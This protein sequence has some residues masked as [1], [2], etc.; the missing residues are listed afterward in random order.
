MHIT[1]GHTKTLGLKPETSRAGSYEEP[2][3]NNHVRKDKDP[4]S[5]TQNLFDTV[6]MR[7]LHRTN[8]SDFDLPWAPSNERTQRVG[9]SNRDGNRVEPQIDGYLSKNAEKDTEKHLI[10]DTEPARIAHNCNLP[11]I[12]CIHD[13]TPVGSK[14]TSSEVIP[15]RGTIQEFTNVKRDPENLET[16][17]DDETNV[18]VNVE[19]KESTQGAAPLEISQPNPQSKRLN[20]AEMA[21]LRKASASV[22]CLSVPTSDFAAQSLSHFT[23]ANIIALKEARAV[24]RSDLYEQHCLLKSLGRTDLPQHSS[25]CGSYGNF[26]A[27]SGQS[28]TYI[29]GHVDALLQSFL[30]FEDSD[31]TS[32]VVWSYDFA[33][34]VDLFRKLRRIDM[35]PHKIFPSLWISVGR[36]YPV[37]ATTNKSR[38]LTISDPGSFSLDP[39]SASPGCSLNDLEA[40]HVVKIVLA[41]LVASVPKCSPLGWL[42]VRKLH[43]A[44]QVAPFVDAGNSP[45][46]GKM[47]GKLVRVLQAFENESALSLV[48]RLA[49][50]IDIRYHLARARELAED[51]EKKHRRRYPPTFSRVIDYI[52]ADKLKV[53]VA[54]NGGQPSIKSGEWVDPDIEP[55]TWH[56]KEWPIVVEWLRAV[57]L[58]EWDGNAKV[59]KGSAVGGALGLMLY[60]RKQS[61]AYL[62]SR[63]LS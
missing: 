55:I 47:I 18:A 43:A 58:K 44:G 33:T 46:E 25:R 61:I 45:A 60:I 41:A 54:G 36:L 30:H 21:P 10:P 48:I 23:S 57:I 42:A 2:R 39:S 5:F 15:D 6:A 49:R 13:V 56:R 14:N 53:S 29:L 4:K 22:E 32:K 52:N 50:S 27:Y 3:T 37:S 35:H 31:A 34:I 17:G 28:M 16:S 7:L 26:L 59:A 19:A 24:R 11:Q 20:V 51:F 63:V 8:A 9:S 38:S 1:N 62:S 40:C 12:E